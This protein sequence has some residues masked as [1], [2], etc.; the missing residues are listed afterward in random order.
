MVMDKNRYVRVVCRAMTVADEPL[1]RMKL[2]VFSR[3]NHT[4][5]LSCDDDASSRII[6]MSLC[7]DIMWC[8]LC[9]CSGASS[10]ALRNNVIF[11]TTGD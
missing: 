2:I 7:L 1:F 9:Y 6:N 11:A 4:Y 8:R 3:K 5:E 10:V